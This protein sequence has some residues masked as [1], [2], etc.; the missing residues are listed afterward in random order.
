[1]EARIAKLEADIA[2]LNEAG[3]VLA[4]ECACSRASFGKAVQSVNMADARYRVNNNPTARA[5]VEEV[6]K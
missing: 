1:M 6:S 5:W 3:R 4:D 2:R